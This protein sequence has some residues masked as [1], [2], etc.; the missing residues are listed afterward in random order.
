MAAE[1]SRLFSF[2]PYLL[3]DVSGEIW[4]DGSWGSL[5]Q[6]ILPT[7]G[8]LPGSWWEIC[9]VQ[10]ANNFNF[11]VILIVFTITTYE[12]N[13]VN[14]YI[15]NNSFVFFLV[16]NIPI[17]NSWFLPLRFFERG[18]LTLYV[19]STFYIRYTLRKT[20]S[21]GQNWWLVLS[22]DISPETDISKMMPGIRCQISFKVVRAS[23]SKSDF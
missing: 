3:D 9:L 11:S 16:L 20:I 12:P 15:N 7:P 23:V 4:E 17:E 6:C 1:R 21:R 8:F 2:A 14:K 18:N 5:V 19:F 22:L 10:I 13:S